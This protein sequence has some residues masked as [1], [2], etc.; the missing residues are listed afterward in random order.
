MTKRA[1]VL[2]LGA[3]LLV[4]CV[5][6]AEG[7]GGPGTSGGASGTSGDPSSSGSSGSSGTSGSSGSS[8]D[9]DN[10]DPSGATRP[11]PSIASVA[12]LE[13][14]YGTL[15]TITGDNLDEA[16]AELV[17]AGPAE[18]VKIKMPPPGTGQ[19]QPGDVVMKWSKTEIQFK[20]PFPAEGAVGITTTSGQATGGSF[21]PSWRP[22]PG[23][24][25]VFTRRELLAIVSPAAGTMVSAYDGATGPQILV[26]KPDGSIEA[27]PFNRGATAIS[28]MS[29]YATPAGA[30]EG[31]FASGGTLYQV[32]NV[33]G[34]PQVTSTGV[35]ALDA[36]GGYDASGPYAWIRK[37]NATLVRVRPPSW[38]ESGAAVSDPTPSG[39]PG[40]SMAVAPDDSL[41]VGWG[42]ND[43][44]SFP[45]YDHTAHPVM[46]RLRAGM[47]TFDAQRTGGSG[48]DDDMVWTRL[49]AGPGG[50]VFS[51]YCA[52]D[53]GFV[54]PSGSLDC[55]E[56]YIDGSGVLSEPTTYSHGETISGWNATTASTASCDTPSSI[57]SI[58]PEG[59]TAQAVKAIFPCM[60]IVG[61]ATD[62]AGEGTFM[63]Q[64][65]SYVYAPRKR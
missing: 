64:A 22:G 41:Y 28:S 15:V 9:Y 32:T 50:R 12:P 6:E 57:V 56:G 44:G 19:S 53:S 42:V 5:S 51:Y 36:A 34:S 29:L 11:P 37:S 14:D 46:R 60:R 35:A 26:A 8:G 1:L 47:T 40:P 18:P 21:A 23:I 17:L 43:S 59:N 24:S 2:G 31:F 52:N 45:T 39:A 61:V 63:V 38:A 3:V 54:D 25:G 65:A 7:T 58:G 62:P 27:K 20:Y 10:G 49:R 33:L 30:V 4:A 16:S 13:G 55:G 48:A